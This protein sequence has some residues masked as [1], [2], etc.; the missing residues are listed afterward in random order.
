MTQRPMARL[1]AGVAVMA[2]VVLMGYPPAA[3]AHVAR[4][5]VSRTTV[6]CSPGPTPLT[7]KSRFNTTPAGHGPWQVPRDPCNTEELLHFDNCAYWADEKRPDIWRYAVLQPKGGY[8]HGAGGGAW[9]I[10]I[11][12]KKYGFNINHK[13][14]RGDIAAWPPNAAMGTEQSGGRTI[15]HFASPGGHVA[16][17]EKVRGKKI[18]I[19]TTGL[20]TL[21]GYTFTIKYNRHRTF[22]IHRGRTQ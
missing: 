15:T 11:D 16:Y 2:T 19:S 21:G 20:S 6:Q 22:F 9:N 3:N 10:K 1:A 4:A 18:T 12:A 14:K 5:A 17:V 7:T 8:S 13:P